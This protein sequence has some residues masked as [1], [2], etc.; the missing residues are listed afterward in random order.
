MF[1]GPGSLDHPRLHREA[2]RV[3]K[4]I[5]TPAQLRKAIAR[6]SPASPIT[7]AFSAKWRA[8]RAKDNTQKERKD[9]WYRTQHEHWLGW[10]RGYEGP[11]GYGRQNWSR[12]A[13]FVYNH[14][15]NPQM[16]IYVAEATEVDGRV[17]KAA[18]KAA[19]QSQATMGSMSGAIRRLIPW[20][21]IEAGLLARR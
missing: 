2:A 10:L 12:S 13:A 1:R 5:D 8:A 9:V 14:I 18:A 21:V 16:L 7:D 11:G 15:V 3:T 19:L 4:R 17:L 20:K 6:L